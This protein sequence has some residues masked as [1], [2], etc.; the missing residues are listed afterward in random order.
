MKHENSLKS[1]TIHGFF[2]SFVDLIMNQGLQFIIQ[3]IL[4]R[5]LLPEHFGVIGMITIFISISNAVV[6]SGFSNALIREKEVSQKD[7]STVFYFNLIIAVL[8]YIILFF[9]APAI[10]NFFD[11]K[12]LINILRILAISL[13]INSFGI[14]QQ[15]MLVR[16]IDFKTQTKINMISSLFSGCIG[17]IAAIMGM[18]VW[19]LVIRTLTMNFIQSLLLISYNRWMPS[20]VF[21][22][23]S[24]KKLFKYGWKM[25][26]SGLID[27]FYCNLYCLIIGKNFSVLE[28]GYYTNADKLKSTVSQSITGAIQ[29]VSYPVLSSIEGGDIKLKSAYKRIIK[30]CAF[31]IFPVMI[32]LAAVGQPLIS[33][34]LGEKWINSIIFFQI[35]CFEGMLYPIHAINLNILQVKGRS[36]LFLKLELIKKV[37]GISIIVI[38][39]AL[40]FGVMGLLWGIVLQCYITYFLNAHYSNILIKYSIKEQLKD[41]YPSFF[42][43]TI[44]GVIVYFIGIT[45]P[46]NNI[47]ILLIQVILGALIY[48]L[49][50]KII[51]SE[52]LS[53][54]MNLII[55]LKHKK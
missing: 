35:L 25:L 31:I 28:L 22:M 45:L 23:N 30:S 34:L 3:I 40:G 11:E 43:S 33:L 38:T 13:I 5:L 46:F 10:S 18:E 12:I 47:I 15:T 14:I 27:T 6:D 21:D 39:L 53:M 16:K 7:Y 29:K 9:S 48:I 55:R 8:I 4:A 37:I 42:S 24:F 41:M 52:E 51:K 32:G 44:M 50:S 19:S 20:L 36:D 49:I 17:I 54:M 26:V 1:K 2:W